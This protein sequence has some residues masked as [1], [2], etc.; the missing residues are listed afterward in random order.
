M[1]KKREGLIPLPQG[2]T[3]GCSAHDGNLTV[4]LTGFPFQ[5]SRNETDHEI[6]HVTGV[7]V[8]DS[9]RLPVVTSH[10][11][12][13]VSARDMYVN[14]IE[15][16][17]KEGSLFPDDLVLQDADGLDLALQLVTNLQ[18]PLRAP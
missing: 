15:W 3:H 8:K 16:N 18:V 7:S 11:V 13:L 17:E 9:H 6:F 10:S 1:N 2:K 5:L 12:T 4:A 14:R